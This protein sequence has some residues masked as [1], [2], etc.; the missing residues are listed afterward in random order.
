METTAGLNPASRMS[1]VRAGF[2]LL[3]GLAACGGMGQPPTE[4]DAALPPVWP[5]E[6][7]VNTCEDFASVGVGSYVISSNY[8]NKVTCPGT[9]CME[10]NTATG[11]FSVTEGPPP[12][13]DNVASFPNVLYGCSYGNCSPK[14]ILPLPVTSVRQLTSSWDFSVGGTSSDRWN[15]AY[16]IWF[17]P[18]DNCGASGFPKGLELMIWLDVKNARGWKDH[19]GTAKLAGYEWDVWVADMAAGGALDS[20]GYMDY[21][22]RPATMTSVKNLDLHAIVQD[23]VARGYV[24]SSWYLYAVQAGMEVRT[25]GMPFNSN[26][27]SLTINGVTPSTAPL[28]YE[29]PSCDGGVPTAEGQLSV[30]DNYVTAGSLHGYGTAGTWVGTDSDAIACGTPTCTVRPEGGISCSPPFPPSALCTAGSI[31]ADSTY[32]SVAW[33]GFNLNQDKAAA[34]GADGLDGGADGLDGG[35]AGADGGVAIPLG[36]ITIPSSITV[37]VT[38]SGTLTG[39]SSLR[40]QLTDV[41]G[42]DYCYGGPMTDAIPITKFN[43]AC[44]NNTGEFA[45]SSTAFRTLE[46]I[47][48][49]SASTEQEFAYCITNVTVQ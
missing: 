33:V 15:V 31:T 23:A 6:V 46:V 9:Q 43:T 34:G 2:D 30:D 38:K 5:A 35:A 32:H 44:W 49:S 1:L 12:C 17:C 37:S 18:D 14:T 36:T 41:N 13:G 20:W 19:L 16:D 28:P 7:T 22:A 24:K 4:V 39:N 40:A 27:Y 48:P 21:I 47:V 3:A 11:A 8:W 25:G 26:S 29:G 45:T 10:I 42:T